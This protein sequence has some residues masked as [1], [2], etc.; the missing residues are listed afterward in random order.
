M[1]SQWELRNAIEQANIKT[2][3]D[4]LKKLQEKAKI[5]PNTIWEARKRAK[6]CKGLEY[7]TYT[8]DGILITDPTE[9]K[10]HIANYFEDLYQAREG[11]EEYKSW[12]KHIEEQV[13]RSL[14]NPPTD[15][16]TAEDTISEKE[17]KYA[18]KKLKRK[19][20]LGPDKIPNEIFIEANKE[21]REILREVIEKVHKSEQIPHS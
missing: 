21:T 18:I 7:N 5:I 14:E 13:R 6:G 19:K 16:T 10:K 1:A 9:T 15:N 3:A 11:T 20:S 2:I 12:I 17:M 4:R 8:G